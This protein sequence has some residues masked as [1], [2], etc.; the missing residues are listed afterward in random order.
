MQKTMD[1]GHTDIIDAFNLITVQL[2]RHRC[3]LRYRQITRTGR[4]DNN[5]SPFFG[6]CLIDDTDLRHRI[7]GKFQCF[8][9]LV[10]LLF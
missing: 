6:L 10:R 9:N 1:T 8:G 4:Y 7:I 2:R 3:L 5:F